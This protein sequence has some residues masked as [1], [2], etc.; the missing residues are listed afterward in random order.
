MAGSNIDDESSDDASLSSC[1]SRERKKKR[2]KRKRKGRRKRESKRKRK[3]KKRQRKRHRRRHDKQ[4]SSDDDN[5]QLHS[6]DCSS[7]TTSYTSDDE[8]DAIGKSAPFNADALLR[9]EGLKINWKG[10]P[11][12]PGVA[13]DA[14]QRVQ[15]IIEY[16]SMWRASGFQKFPSAEILSKRLK[17]S[18]ETVRKTLNNWKENMTMTDHKKVKRGHAVGVGTFSL[19]DGD[20]QLIL[21]LRRLQP[22]RSL[23]NYAAELQLQRRRI[24]SVATISRLFLRAFRF[25]AA[26]T[27]TH[28]VPFDKFTPHNLI[29]YDRYI[30][31][32]AKFP[33]RR[34]KFGDEK[35]LKNEEMYTKRSRRDPET[36]VQTPE[37]V[38]SDFR[39]AHNL[40]CLMSLND[41]SDNP[42]LFYSLGEDNGT[43]LSFVALVMHACQCGFFSPWDI[44]VIDNARIHDCFET[45]D[46]ADL[47]WNFPGE[48]G[49]A[50]RVLLV[51]L[52]TRSPELNP[53]ELIFNTFVKRLKKLRRENPQSYRELGALESAKLT[54]DE[55]EIDLMISTATHCGYTFDD[56]E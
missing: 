19:D 11:Y 43:A 12:K 56:S 42:A 20:I 26:M 6:S 7:S 47:L 24:V 35:H 36:G 33:H 10:R 49:E 51:Y 28:L 16:H 21:E 31:F 1:E 40:I 15:V 54:L 39:N 8:S 52:P 5:R 22:T 23:E 27:R 34:V 50:L 2:K 17:L 32:I 3:R 37:V 18:R 38:E 4:Y 13:I 41:E 53:I 14:S 9:S 48:G 30:E 25:K 44:F 29:R 55:M 46:L 45:D